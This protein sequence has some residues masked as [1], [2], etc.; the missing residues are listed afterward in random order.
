MRKI[1][2]NT[3]V[4][5]IGG[6]INGM[7]TARELL[8]A[9]ASVRLL[10]RGECGR[11]ASWAG[12]GIISPLYPWRYPDAI[13]A[14]STWAQ[15]FYPSL[16]DELLAETGIDP[17]LDAHGLLVLASEERQ[18]AI[19]W[20]ARHG[21]QI[22]VLN[23]M[24]LKE[25]FPHLRI[26]EPEGLWMPGVA[27]VRNPRL[28]QALKACLLRESKFEL[29][30]HCAVDEIIANSATSIEVHG[31]SQLQSNRVDSL[32]F[33]A[34][35][36]VLCAGAWSTEILSRN[37][38][39]LAIEP[40]K[41]EMLLYK[42]A[43]GLLQNI[44]LNDGRYLIPRRDG[45]IL[46]GSTLERVGFDKTIT[47]AAGISLQESAITMLPELESL[48]PI[49]QWAGLRPA[50]PVG[51]PY[52]GA[53]GDSESIYV[54]AGQF[55]NGLVLAPASARLISALVLGLEPNVDPAPYTFSAQ[56]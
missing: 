39:E 41:G 30:E 35:N 10:E 22:E 50:A 49:G 29:I 24:D 17:E 38:V 25:S 2:K 7:L 55:R 51:I 21:R 47:T 53:V 44:V 26:S 13:T 36:V 8:K 14:L 16:V 19:E 9:G 54:C 40:V 27:S 6:G 33:A 28:L 43:P 46:V 31:G 23:A 32:S 42:A 34:A 3:D 37:G 5:V 15:D 12:G 56:R 4:L 1:S 20:S 48:Q 45:H 11:E 52:I 18:Q